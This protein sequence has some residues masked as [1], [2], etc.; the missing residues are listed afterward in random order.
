MPPSSTHTRTQIRPCCTWQNGPVPFIW[1][2]A[3]ADNTSF[4]VSRESSE[5][6]RLMNLRVRSYHSV[7]YA[8]TSGVNSMRLWLCYIQGRVGLLCRH[9]SSIAPAGSSSSPSLSKSSTELI[10]PSSSPSSPSS[11][12]TLFDAYFATYSNPV[13]KV[14]Q[15][16]DG[17]SSEVRW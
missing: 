17:I 3:R 1:P 10:S 14:G 15:T 2:S 4:N 11:R 8:D 6:N 12:S 16:S 9:T 13:S 7:P 5:M